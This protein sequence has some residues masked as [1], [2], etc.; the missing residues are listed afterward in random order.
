MGTAYSSCDG[1][2]TVV[3]P[4]S[5]SVPSLYLASCCGI[6]W[7]RQKQQMELYLEAADYGDI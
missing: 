3:T 7:E 2:A 4:Y 6:H 1:F 5:F